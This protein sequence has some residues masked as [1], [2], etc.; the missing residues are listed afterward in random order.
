MSP[1]N[2]DQP[3]EDQPSEDPIDEELKDLLS[4]L[5]DDDDIDED[6][7]DE[8]IP[9]APVKIPK[10]IKTTAIS[11][12]ETSTPTDILDDMVESFK[13]TSTVIIGNFNTDREDLQEVID[14]LKEKM[15]GTGKMERVEIEALA[16]ILATKAQ[17]GTNAVKLLDAFAKF[18]SA[19]KNTKAVDAHGVDF[20]LES[21][22][23]E[24]N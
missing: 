19:S 2:K 6:I 13:S 15:F 3:S 11:A 22:L 16:S 23:E 10:T 7:A 18:M 8:L 21:L 24:Q 1:E 12:E 17:Q 9:V 4:S 20:D 5:S 14:H